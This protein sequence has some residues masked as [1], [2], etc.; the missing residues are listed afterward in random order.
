MGS[1]QVHTSDVSH[2][3]D[4]DVD[5][6]LVLSPRCTVSSLPTISTWE[7]IHSSNSTAEELGLTPELTE[8]FENR[9]T[10]MDKEF[11]VLSTKAT[12]SSEERKRRINNM[13]SS[14]ED[15]SDNV[16]QSIPIK[17]VR[18]TASHSL[19][20]NSEQETIKNMVSL[21]DFI[22]AS[23]SQNLQID[24][25]IQSTG[26]FFNTQIN[27][28]NPNTAAVATTSTRTMRSDLE[29]VQ[30][31]E[32]EPLII[33]VEPMVECAEQYFSN[34]LTVFRSLRNSVIEKSE[35]LDTYRNLKKKVQVFKLKTRTYI[36]EILELNQLGEFKIK[37]YEPNG[38]NQDKFKIG[39]IGPIHF[40]TS[41]EEVKKLLHEAGFENRKVERMKTKK[42]GILI[43]VKT[44]KIWFDA[45]KF[46]ETVKLMYEQFKVTAYVP[47]PWQCYRCQGFGHDAKNCKRG[48]KCVFCAGD[49][50]VEVCPNK[51]DGQRKCTNCSGNH[52]ANYGGCVH[53]KNENN[54]QKL[55]VM[56]NISY[57]DAVKKANDK[58]QVNEMEQSSNDS[59]PTTS[60]QPQAKSAPINVT[61]RAKVIKANSSTQTDD[62]MNIIL[63]NNSTETDMVQLAACLLEMIPQIGKESNLRKKCAITC[64]L[65][66]K[67]LGKNLEVN[68]L[69]TCSSQRMKK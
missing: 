54:V 12:H 23:S 30:Q 6:S 24:E 64:Q 34:A 67:Y 20:Q 53:V 58:I 66:K 31:N 40:N 39:L 18:Y 47:R 7:S 5:E 43:E 22:P 62:E 35:I 17:K 9:T 59:N 44:M 21:H 46:P 27:S 14:T 3:S 63:N 8:K 29:E 42:E 19:R 33:I 65:F 55:R 37:C 57:R 38:K 41:P 2:V 10:K 68:D 26:T 49:H 4:S 50:L 28:N 56:E 25:T 36:N 69:I 16:E 52:T 1:S 32:V 48:P 51:N 15:V 45:D 11:P 13:E 61:T 60:H